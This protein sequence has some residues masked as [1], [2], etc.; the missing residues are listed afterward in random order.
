MK[1]KFTKQDFQ[2]AAVSAAADLFKGQEKTNGT[3]SVI[4]ENQV[5]LHETDLGI[6]NHISISREKLLEN[7]HEVQ[8]RNNLPLTDDI[9]DMQF[10]IE[11]E[12]GAGKTYVFA[13]T[14]FELNKLYGF[15]KFIIVVPSISVREGDYKFLQISEEHFGLEYNRAPVRYF[16][17]NSQRL[18]DVRQFAT[19]GNIEIMIIN[20]DAFKKAENIINQAQDR[21][22]GESAMEFIR[23]TRPVL[24]IDEPQSVDHTEK[25]KDALAA[26]NPLCTFRYSATFRDTT[27]LIY[28][29]TPVDAFEMGIVKQI[30]VISAQAGADASEAYIRLLSVDNSNGFKAKVEID[31][32]NKAGKAERKS[33]TVKPN[34]DLFVLSGNREI[35]NGYVVAGI[36]CTKG[37]ESIEFDNA[38]IVKLG[39]AIG[40]VDD[41]LIKR[42]QIR[43]T[44]ETHLQKELMYYEKGIKVLSLFFIDKVANYRGEENGKGIYA[45]IFEELYDELINQPRFKSLK[46]KFPFPVDKVHGG[47]FSQ[48]KKGRLKNTRGDTNDDADTYNAIMRDKEWLLSFECPLRFI[49]S[50]SALRE[51]WDNPNVFQVCT[52]IDQ[53]SM[54]TCRQ[55]IGRGMRLCV[56]KNGDRITD[57]DVNILHVVG[58]ESVGEFADRLQK[59]YEEDT[60]IKFGVINI[61]LFN[62]ITYTETISEEKVI[63]H[64]HAEKV[65]S[66]YRE[67]GLLDDNGVIAA[68]ADKK[69][70]DERVPEEIKEVMPVMENMAKMSEPITALA[71]KSFVREKTEEKSITYETAKSLV[72]HLEE[73]GYITKTGK[74]KDTMKEALKNNTLD[75]PKR[76][77]AA[78]EKLTEAIRKADKKVIIRDASKDVVVKLK[79]DVI[80]SP[81]FLELWDKLKYKTTYRIK[82]DENEF[83]RLCIDSI[84][85][86]PK[87]PKAHIVSA[88][89]DISVNRQGIGYNERSVKTTVLDYDTVFLPN[90]IDSVCEACVINRRTC[91]DIILGCERC[92]EFYNNPNLFIENVID[93]INDVS[94]KLS[95]AG[96]KYHKLAGEEY[97][98]QEIFDSGELLANLDKNAVAVERS[99]YNY[100]TYDSETVERPMAVALDNDPEVKMFFKIPSKFKIR[101]PLGM[102]NPDWAVMLEK[103]GE[104]KLYFVLETKGST[105]NLDLRDR[106]KLKIHCGQ[107]HFKALDN[108]VVFQKADN[109]SKFK[110]KSVE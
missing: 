84:N 74:I 14:I 94:Y 26:L 28:R 71:G 77:E 106:E 68:D 43:R 42:E 27:N 78:K 39:Q 9:D 18:S 73:K 52:L 37:F 100:V 51:G 87:I 10:S 79:K 15:T 29:L 85:N 47:Y 24:I 16:I 69:L 61:S 56:N 7:L 31:K 70:T 40:G 104:Q 105:I 8:K 76:F 98:I 57:R 102:Y 48:D 58:N 101:T 34:D 65:I 23:G 53:K 92:G 33:V 72:E 60:G 67:K 32:L 96:I 36:D 107:E 108:G 55:K 17:Y 2:M 44:I 22:N 97:Y 82:I 11:M 90:I 81:E 88:A 75:L 63:D 99:V 20:I 54:F 19:S 38:E 86:M 103:N 1:L 62:G 66:F 5:S 25:A 13:R 45:G 41:L 89:A 30:S 93:C 12:T 95:I 59:E 91:R 83:K 6:R 4:K 3:F 49:F 109:W 50:H 110:T 21:L 80:I 35:Y 64:N 46:G